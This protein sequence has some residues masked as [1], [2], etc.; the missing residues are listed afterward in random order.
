MQ[1]PTRNE[2]TFNAEPDYAAKDPM[3]SSLVIRDCN[4]VSPSAGGRGRLHTDDYLIRRSH[5]AKWPAFWGNDGS[6]NVFTESPK[7][8]IDI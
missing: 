1:Q 4:A 8:R 5:F 2:G 6:R 3:A 7:C